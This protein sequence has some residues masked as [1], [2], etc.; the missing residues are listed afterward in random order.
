[1][2]W[3]T[4]PSGTDQLVAGLSHRELKAVWPL[5]HYGQMLQCKTQGQ[6]QNLFSHWVRLSLMESVTNLKSYN[7]KGKNDH[8]SYF[9]ALYVF[10][11]H[12][13]QFIWQ[14]DFCL[15]EIK[16]HCGLFLSEACPQERTVS[17]QN[18]TLI[19]SV[20]LTSQTDTNHVKAHCC[21]FS[22]T[23]RETFGDFF[24]FNLF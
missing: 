8:R 1:M 21:K 6:E 10:L 24:F 20:R 5:C 12:S 11:S 19:L 2:T 22:T 16:E 7:V 3:W 9:P 14:V 23:T 17:D 15:S 4:R 13:S 18:I